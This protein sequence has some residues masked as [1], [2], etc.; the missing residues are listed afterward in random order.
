M[1]IGADGVDQQAFIDFAG[2]DA[3]GVVFSTHGF[4][5]EGSKFQAFVEGMT[6]AG[7]TPD[8]PALG[9]LGGDIIDVIK[10]AV[11]KAGSIEPA[12]LAKAL[13][14]L[15]NVPVINGTI[16]YKGTNGVPQKTVFIAGIED[17][18]FV[19]EDQFIPAFI[20]EP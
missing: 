10:A 3:E 20:P 17:G 19:L 7:K 2:K 5:T 18:K 14:E 4:P 8:A 9:S 13:E 15:E 11:E 1:L 12:A 16:T 6:A